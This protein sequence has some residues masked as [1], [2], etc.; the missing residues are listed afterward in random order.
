MKR[1]QLLEVTDRDQFVRD[2]QTDYARSLR[3]AVPEIGRPLPVPL[4]DKAA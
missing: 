1:G 2:P 3:D 4:A